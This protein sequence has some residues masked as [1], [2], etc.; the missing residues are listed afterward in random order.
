VHRAPNLIIV[1]LDNHLLH[2]LNPKNRNSMPV[3]LVAGEA[4]QQRTH[5]TL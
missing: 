2:E 1:E 3:Q 5:P 4:E